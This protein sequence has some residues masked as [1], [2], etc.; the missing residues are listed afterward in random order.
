MRED[1]MGT[2]PADTVGRTEVLCICGSI[3][4]TE[5]IPDEP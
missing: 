4:I 2:Q 3:R 1:R 5:E